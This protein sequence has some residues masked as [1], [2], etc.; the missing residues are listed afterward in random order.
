M[1]NT[2]LIAAQPMSDRRNRSP[3]VSKGISRCQPSNQSLIMEYCRMNF[4]AAK[5]MPKP[6]EI[7]LVED[8]Q[9]DVLLTKKA[10]KNKQK[11]RRSE[12]TK[13]RLDALW[14]FRLAG[15]KFSSQKIPFKF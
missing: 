10:L 1:T 13:V 3:A 15:L 7:L 9:G 2:L 8:D 14:K 4:L 5:P 12:N 11:S 6:I